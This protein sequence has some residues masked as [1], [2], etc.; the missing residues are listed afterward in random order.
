[1][2]RMKS[3]V[4]SW[5]WI[6]SVNIFLVLTNLVIGFSLTRDFTK[7]QAASALLSVLVSTYRGGEKNRIL[8]L[9]IPLRL[10]PLPRSH[11]PSM[12]QRHPLHS[13]LLHRLPCSRLL[14]LQLRLHCLFLQKNGGSIH[15]CPQGSV[16][17]QK[18]ST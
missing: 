6:Y 9:T 1:M 15:C 5:N 4:R 11:L 17:L 13:N 14:R 16:R 10:R 18:R 3:I 7:G 12:D 8:P 2:L